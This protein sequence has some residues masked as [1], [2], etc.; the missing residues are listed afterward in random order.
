M[1]SGSP[2][3]A[4]LPAVDAN[5]VVARARDAGTTRQLLLEAAR[6]RFARDGYAATTVR[7]IAS[8]A[9]VNVALI[10]RYFTSKE[11]LFE[12]CLARVVKDLDRPDA[13]D[14]SIDQMIA[15]MVGQVID[16]VSGEHPLQ[17]L[18]LL[19]SSG[20]EAADRIRKNTL[21]SFTERMATV[22][23]WRPDA[24]QTKHLVLR[25]QVA[26]STALGVVLLRASSQVEP[27]TSADASE[28]GDALNDVFRTLLVSPR[29]RSH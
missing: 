17:L 15:Y 25:A 18:L 7:D 3:V 21:N 6:H 13:E 1:T 22:A 19:R 4:D 29:A 23:G 27:L 11:G 28:L 5:A 16:S 9:G 10:N 2:P 24:S 12:S 20:D 26:L 8:D 14:E